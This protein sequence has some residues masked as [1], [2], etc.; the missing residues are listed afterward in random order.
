MAACRPEFAQRIADEP[1]LC[2][3]RFPNGDVADAY[4]AAYAEWLAD[5][6][7]IPRPIWTSDPQRVARE[8][9]FSTPLRGHLLVVSPASFRQRNLFT[10]PEL[11]FHPRAGRPCVSA[12]EKHRKALLRQHAYRDR[13]RLLVAKARK[14]P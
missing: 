13:I 3:D 7:E 6:A 8:P 1:P 14:D 12:E 2:A 5:R 9:W 10:V 11:V 4:L